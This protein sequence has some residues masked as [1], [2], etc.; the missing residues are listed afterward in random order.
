MTPS[1]TVQWLIP[2]ELTTQSSLTHN[3]PGAIN[4]LYHSIKL[5][6]HIASI[7]NQ[8]HDQERD[9]GTGSSSPSPR[10]SKQAPEPPSQTHHIDIGKFVAMEAAMVSWRAELPDSLRL[11]C[12]T[13]LR[14]N[15]EECRDIDRRSIVLRALY[16]SS[17]S[18]HVPERV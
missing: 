6:E 5:Q 13:T 10:T 9:L 8:S 15:S 17:P 12:L 2:S 1:R 3:A 14:E 4:F 11:P 7:V 18:I 16:D